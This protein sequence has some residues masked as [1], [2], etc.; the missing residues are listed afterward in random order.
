MKHPTPSLMTLTCLTM[1]EADVAYAILIESAAWLNSR[2]LPAWLMPRPL[3]DQRIAQRCLYGASVEENLVGVMSL[4]DTYH[5]EP[6]ADLLPNEHFF[7][8]STVHVARA[9]AGQG[10]GSFL[11]Q[12]AEEIAQQHGVTHIVLD[13]YYGD[14]TLPAYYQ[15]HGYEWIERLVTVYDGIAHDDVLLWKIITP[16]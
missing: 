6:W 16:A 4:T 5:P 12:A 11:L 15:R 2:D 14:G 1:Y 3:F 9:F 10:V 13:C 8:L 7:W